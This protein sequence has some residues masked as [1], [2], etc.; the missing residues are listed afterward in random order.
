MAT[1]TSSINNKNGHDADSPLNV[2]FITNM[3]S[4][5]TEFHSRVSSLP[6][7]VTAEMASLEN[8]KTLID[9]IKKCSII[10][11]EPVLI[12]NHLHHANNL[13]WIQLIMAGIDKAMGFVDINTVN[14]K[15]T[16]AGG[17]SF[18]PMMAEFIIGR[19][20][21]H[22]RHFHQ[23]DQFQQDRRWK[24]D[25][26]YSFRTLKELKVGIMGASGS[27]GEKI[28]ENCKFFGMKTRGLASKIPSNKTKDFID[29]WF[30]TDWNDK[31]KP[32]KIP[33]KFFNDLDYLVNVLPSTPA[34][35][36]M[37]DGEVL[38]NC[39]TNL[40]NPAQTVFMNIGRGDVISDESLL[41]A[42]LGSSYHSLIESSPASKLP[43]PENDRYLA[44]AVLDVFNIEP[45][46]PTHPF[47]ALSPPLLTIS[48]HVSGMS[49]AAKKEIVDLFFENLQKFLS[50]EE[51]LYEVD[52]GKGY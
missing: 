32:A 13:K 19:M 44:S 10:F 50:G 31:T 16:R 11:G 6:S 2:L 38:S 23:W 36:G 3:P 20:L 8:E 51:L 29:E 42:L 28:A 26:T 24:S 22:E 1:S 17:E 39:R 43:V 34:T 4:I 12:K 9:Q 47:Y 5:I 37:L 27:I 30:I 18:G 14:Y 21:A 25:P 45:L 46:P 15:V 48:P 52:A 33:N 49:G 35:K 41:R 7:N 40:S